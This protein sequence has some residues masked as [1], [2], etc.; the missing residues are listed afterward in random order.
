MTVIKKLQL[1]ARVLKDSNNSEIYESRSGY[2]MRREYMPNASGE[3]VIWGDWVLRA[4]DGGYID[5]DIYRHDLAER[6]DI[7]LVYRT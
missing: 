2:S 6:H 5:R 3:K 4:P 1:R 7:D